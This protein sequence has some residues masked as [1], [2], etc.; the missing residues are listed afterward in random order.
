MSLNGREAVCSIF[1]MTVCSDGQRRPMMFCFRVSVALFIVL[2][3]SVQR[4]AV[5]CLLKKYI[6]LN[7]LKFFFSR[8]PPIFRGVNKKA[9]H[10][11]V[12]TGRRPSSSRS[13]SHH[14]RKGIEKVNTKLMA[15]ATSSHPL[16]ISHSRH[17]LYYVTYMYSQ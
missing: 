12:V 17:C 8:I 3:P 14:I 6:E 15:L 5:A 16:K 9:C 7:L 11:A 4:E 1:V 10:N 13:I 2:S